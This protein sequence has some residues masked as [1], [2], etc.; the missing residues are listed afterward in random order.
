MPYILG[1]QLPERRRTSMSDM[2]WT[3]LERTDGS[4]SA[5][6]TLFLVLLPKLFVTA[7]VLMI[8]VDGALQ[9][10]EMAITGGSLPFVPKWHILLVL[11]LGSMLLLKGRFQSSALLPLTLLLLAYF[12]LEV[13]FLH[14]YKELSFTSVRLS[15]E[16]FFLLF[17]AAAASVVPLQLKAQHVLAF[18][19]VIT[20]ACLIVSA[21][22]FLTNLPVVPTESADHIFQVQAYG[23]LGRTRAFSLCGSPL[24]A[25]IFYLFMGAVA[26]SFCLQPG[27]RTF[28]LFL[29]SLCA[30]GCYATYT[31]LVMFGFILT[32]IA[33]FAMSRKGLA[34]FSS[35]LPIF[36]LGCAMLLIA[37]GIRTAGGAGRNDLA[38][39]SS[40]DQRVLDWAMYSKKFLAGSPVDILF[41]TGL[42]SYAPYTLP[43]RAENAAPVPVDNTYLLILLSTGICGLVLM[44]VAYWHFWT[45]LHKRAIVSNSPLFIGITGMFAIVPFLG[46]ISDPPAQVILLL[47]LAVSLDERDDVI[48]VSVPST[49]TEPYLTVA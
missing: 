12:V 16:Y 15:L 8:I 3:P 1:L 6:E 25:G 19:L 36:S 28:G 32:T 11:G 48:S 4:Q 27:R 45:F 18:L 41:G 49:S 7:V 47:L 13:L 14:F 2:F 20:F 34:K 46:S 21:A 31:R 24:Q 37:Q 38:N 43:D 39:S 5:A 10:L 30:F 23:F 42:A 17:I 44:G 35:L 22:Q 26:T 40:L 33:V 29:L 9:Q